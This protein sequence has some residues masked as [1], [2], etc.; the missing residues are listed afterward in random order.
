MKIKKLSLKVQIALNVLF[1]FIMLPLSLTIFFVLK[2]DTLN[3]STAELSN[4]TELIKSNIELYAESAVENHLRS[5]AEKAKDFV[6]YEYNRFVRGE[7]TEETAYSLSREVLLDETFGKIGTTGYLAGIDSNG[8]LAIH[9]KSEGVDASGF[10]FMQKAIEMKEGYLEYMWKNKGEAEERS[11]AGY[12]SYFAPWD[13][14]VWASS[15]TAEFMYLVKVDLLK[16]MIEELLIG[17]DGY[18]IVIDSSGGIVFHPH[19]PDGNL[20]SDKTGSPVNRE[21]RQ[22]VDS[23]GEDVDANITG[24][25]FCETDG[26]ERLLSAAYIEVMDWY[27]LTS[28]PTSEVFTIVM[29]IGRIL[30]F[31]CLFT[32]VLMNLVIFLV[33]RWLL[34]PLH[35]I[36]TI[37]TAV[38]K[39]DITRVVEITSHDETGMIAEQVN[40]MTENVRG[41]LHRMKGDVMTL[42]NSIQE[43]SSSSSEIS[44]TSNEQASAVKEIVST[45]EDSDSLS[46]SV[47]KKIFEV[48]QISDHLRSTVNSGVNNVEESLVKME[49]IRISNHDTI[50]G[51]RSLSEKIEAIWEIVT[52]INSI[53]DQTKIIAFNAELEASAAGEAGKNFQ[54]VA[55]EI[56]RLANSTVSSTSEIKNKINEI[57]HSSDRLITASE[58]GTN[59]IEDGGKL[60]ETLHNTFE[61]IME[62]AEISADS[63]MDIST[64]IR[65][66]VLAFEQILLT[67]KQISEG[68]NNFVVSTKSTSEITQN[69]K[70]M[71]DSMNGFLS[72]YKTEVE[73]D[74]RDWEHEF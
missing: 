31:V 64:S 62:S 32:F 56:R 52:I 73:E 39:G 50:A 40:T 55:S 25:F 35:E 36:K 24:L 67:L 14:I 48:A 46:K 68:I 17:T 59:K 33:F 16:D 71:S 2:E 5:I 61:E 29:R 19:Q 8:V 4:T 11:K 44:T 18:P 53:A 7:I 70:T 60:T 34:R 9:P 3:R 49:E 15:Y 72:S 54:I 42:N 37:V 20:F 65:Q 74:E 22:L 6:E 69:L 30:V 66:Q 12:L 45:M 26:T 51:I 63:A 21:L 13:R 41:I 47:E 27:I 23:I 57:Q 38:S 43:L 28:L 10:E 58:D 1:L